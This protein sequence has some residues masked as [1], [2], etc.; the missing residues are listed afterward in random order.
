MKSEQSLNVTPV[1]T[2][3]ELLLAPLLEKLRG[4]SEAYQAG[5][6]EARLSILLDSVIE[7]DV[8]LGKGRVILARE[9]LEAALKRFPS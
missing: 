3:G 8:A 6:L 1:L 5:S 7:A 4:C 2:P 9:T